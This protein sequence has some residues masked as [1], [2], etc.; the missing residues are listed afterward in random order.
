MIW[1]SEALVKGVREYVRVVDG[2]GDDELELELR[3]PEER[4]RILVLYRCS[5]EVRGRYVVR[6]VAPETECEILVSG[7]VAEA[8]RKEMEMRIEFVPGCVGAKAQER[9][10][11]ILTGEPAVN[12]SWP[13]M[14]CGEERVTGTHG[15]AVGR[16]DEEQVR[17]LRSRGLAEDVARNVL[18]RAKL[19]QA[20]NKIMDEKSKKRAQKWVD[21]L[22]LEVV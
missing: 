19:V 13:V 10:E 5:G 8:A 2:A 7:V 4:A 16:I 17:Y 3:E 1:R 14:L 22:K 18:M 11:V 20:V 6:Q 9:E 21:G 12:V 15:V